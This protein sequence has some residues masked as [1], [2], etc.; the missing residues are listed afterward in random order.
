MGYRAA[1]AER[2]AGQLETRLDGAPLA[3]L[4]REALVLLAK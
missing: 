3:E 2:A 1:E 4:V